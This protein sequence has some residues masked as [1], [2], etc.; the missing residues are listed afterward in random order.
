MNHVNYLYLLNYKRRDSIY[1]EKMSLFNFWSKPD[2]KG[3]NKLC[4]GKLCTQTNTKGKKTLVITLFTIILILE[5]QRDVDRQ[6]RKVGRGIERDRRQLER[7]E[8]KLVSI[9]M[10][11]K[12]NI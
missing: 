3:K 12:S 4:I 8:K 10:K 1:Y 2:P 9:L 11:G 5:E 6:L 7:E